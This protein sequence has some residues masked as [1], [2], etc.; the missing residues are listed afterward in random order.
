MVVTAEW[1]CHS[2]TRARPEDVCVRV[3]VYI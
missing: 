2:N 3:P 1:A